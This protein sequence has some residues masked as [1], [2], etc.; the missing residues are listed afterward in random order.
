MH[1][2]PFTRDTKIYSATSSGVE[3]FTGT[4]L[5]SNLPVAI[6]ETQQA[7]LDDA[8]SAIQEAMTQRGL[9]HPGI[10]KV[11]HCFVEQNSD[12]VTLKTVL[13]VE[14][15]DSDLAKE[16]ERRAGIGDMWS[17]GELMACVRTAVAAL[18]YAQQ[19]GVSH[20][21]IK[22]QNIFITQG[23]VKIGDFGS[24][25][26]AFGGGNFMTKTLQGSPL[27][28][29]PELKA[30]YAN[31][32]QGLPANDEYD[33]FR[34]DM[35]SFGMTMAHL[36][37]LKPPIEMLNLMNLQQ[38]TQTVCAEIQMMYPELG[39]WIAVMLN[40]DP[41]RVNF[42]ELERLLDQQNVPQQ[43]PSM[44]VPFMPPVQMP[45]PPNASDSPAL[46]HSYSL[47]RP[48]L[49]FNNPAQAYSSYMPQFTGAMQQ[50]NFTGPPA[51]QRAGSYQFPVIPPVQAQYFPPPAQRPSSPRLCLVCGCQVLPQ[52]HHKNFCS[53]Q[54][55]NKGFQ[56]C[57]AC[58]RRQVTTLSW[59]CSLS[60]DYKPYRDQSYQYC[61]QTCFQSAFPT[62]RC[63]SC[64]HWVASYTTNKRG[65]NYCMPCTEQY[66]AR[67]GF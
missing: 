65:K 36:A 45:A 46:M 63:L 38:S 19:M 61:S 53:K 3:V 66:R 25:H 22:P 6:K 14:L 8:N 33:P 23:N 13:L 51:L 21:D 41:G 2:H 42:I 15:M 32:L 27:F 67:Q 58:K 9:N 1:K 60:S 18:S 29:S 55:S 49:P 17:E 24:S 37:R 39:Q 28:L 5:G 20:R 62:K 34:S 44:P 64:G 11:Y 54:C 12:G 31:I 56:S 57:K 30:K 7:T 43:A 48:P 10:C 26:Q 52:S 59:L 40:T 35:Y 16:A 47:P 4:L 50:P